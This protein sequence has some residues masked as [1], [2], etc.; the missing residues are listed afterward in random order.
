[1]YALAI[2]AFGKSIIA[3]RL[4][5][6]L[7][8]M[9][10]AILIYYICRSV[11]NSKLSLLAAIIFIILTGPLMDGKS[12]MTEHI[13]IV[14]LL[15]SLALLVS[16]NKLININFFLVGLLMGSACMIRLNLAYLALILG[17]YI[18][19]KSIKVNSI[20]KSFLAIFAYGI[21]CLIPFLALLIPY[22]LTNNIQIFKTSV[23]DASLSY[24]NAQASLWELIFKQLYDV[25]GIIFL[26]GCFQMLR[27]IKESKKSSAKQNQL[28]YCLIF[29]VGIEW[30]ILNSGAAHNHYMIQLAPFFAV[31]LASWFQKILNFNLKA[32]Y[33][34]LIFTLIL[35]A[36]PTFNEYQT[37]GSRLVAQQS[38]SYGKEYDL[39]QYLSEEGGR[40][41]TVYM[42]EYHLV[43][44]L[45]DIKPP[46]KIVTHPSNISREYLLRVVQSPTTNTNQELLKVLA[47]KPEFIVKNEN[48]WY[49]QDHPEA[50]ALLETTLETDYTLLKNME[51]TQIY[52]KISNVAQ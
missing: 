27:M 19:A 9:I 42:M 10:A 16:K 30:S 1:S 38:M 49:L 7:C 20:K 31:I 25:W 45:L 23:I 21:G 37:V 41:M 22:I 29:F 2:L 3:V 47:Q 24:S 39:A 40:N 5:G 51:E 17:L 8:V 35:A 43:Y 52:R 33:F 36:L 11:W 34:I 13:A 4:F 44:W 50:I 46:T 18:A 48:V 32:G 6:T 14:P 15:G 28:I 26:I 12:V